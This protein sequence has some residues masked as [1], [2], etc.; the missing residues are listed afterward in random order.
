MTA[1]RLFRV[2]LVAGAVA[3]AL[4]APLV[5]PNFALSILALVFIAALLASSVN[6][7]VGQV[8]LLSIGH[9]GIAACAAYAVAW[10]TVRD[11]DPLIQV[12]LAALA[13]VAVSAVYAVT[14]MRTRGIVFL[15]I[16]LALGM[17]VFGLALRL[18]TIT[19][20]QNGLTGISRP[21]LV[22]EPSTF[23]GLTV[24]VF[25]TAVA[26]LWVIGRS[27]FGLTMRGVRDSESRMASLGYSVS[28]IKFVAV[29]MS[30][31]IAGLAGVLAVWQAQFM[32]PAVAAFGRSALAVVMVILGGTGT[33]LGPFV[34]AGIVVGT[35]HWLSSYVERWP[36][37]LGLIFIAVVLFAR[38]GVVGEAIVLGHRL[39]GR[40]GDIATLQPVVE[41][42]PLAVETGTRSPISSKEEE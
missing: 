16:T 22:A 30:G 2:G 34:G 27:P 41:G 28:S 7:L 18:A 15:M 40:D 36:T 13:T 6:M 12:A 37:V 23:Y 19:G 8:G 9:A 21:P 26:V 33:L 11:H 5:L 38:R 42:L 25:A 29:M 4:S 14:T 20:G 24:L 32:S 3:V 39:L 17:I 35:E 31:L 1:E 10:A